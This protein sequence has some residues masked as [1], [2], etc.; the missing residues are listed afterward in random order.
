MVLSD[1]DTTGGGILIPPAEAG[2]EVKTLPTQEQ[3]SLHKI[4]PTEVGGVSKFG[5]RAVRR[6]KTR[7]K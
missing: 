4:P 1:F 6:L 2:G 7:H 5:Q 3:T